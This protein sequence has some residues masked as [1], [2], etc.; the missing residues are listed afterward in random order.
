MSYDFGLRPPFMVQPVHLFGV[1]A[2]RLRN[3]VRGNE[4]VLQTRQHPPLDL[5]A[6]DGAVVVARPAT[7][8][9][10]AA[11]AAGSQDADLAATTSA[12]EKAGMK[13][14]GSVGQLYRF[15]RPSRVRACPCGPASSRCCRMRSAASSTSAG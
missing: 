7:M 6:R 13:G 15:A 8:M 11:V 2:H 9:V 12:G 4:A 3:R 1:G 10:E 5:L 14:D